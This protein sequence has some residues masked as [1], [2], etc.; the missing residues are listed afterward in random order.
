[1][2]LKVPAEPKDDVVDKEV[3]CRYGWDISNCQKLTRVI[4]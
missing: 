4:R 3:V 1:V 2:R